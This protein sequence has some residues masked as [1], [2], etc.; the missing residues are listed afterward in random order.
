MVKRDVCIIIPA[1]NEE[2]SIAKVIKQ[3]K[4]LGKGFYIVVVNDGSKDQTSSLAKNQGALVLDIPI[5]LGIGGAVQTGL[6]YAKGNGFDIAIQIDADGQHDPK[7]IPKLLGSLKGNDLVI[8]SR[9]VKKTAYPSSTLRTLANRI[10]SWLI[11]LTC[12][13]KIY[14]STSGY[15]VFGPNAIGFFSRYY[16]IDFP[17]PRSIVA[18]LK[19]GYKIKE[20]G[21]LM[22]PRQA[23]KSSVTFLKGIYLILSISIAI[24]FESIHYKDA[25]YE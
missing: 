8:G 14:D 22:K 16:P 13:S 12:N 17:E 15:R 11:R 23:G 9:F 20:V 19:S 3:I 6:K 5:N 10:F 25:T 24:L 1:Y 21:T 7:D 4:K 2:A 18:F